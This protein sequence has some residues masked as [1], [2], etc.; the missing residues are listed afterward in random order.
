MNTMKY[1]QNSLIY[2]WTKSE[3]RSNLC[4]GKRNKIKKLIDSL[5]K[6]RIFGKEDEYG[7]IG[8][9]K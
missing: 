4:D 5:G 9:K 2:F 1:Y 6:T 3:S 8:D 7:E